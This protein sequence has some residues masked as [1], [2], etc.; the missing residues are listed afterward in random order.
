MTD[1]E[2]IKRAKKAV[3][4]RPGTYKNYDVRMVWYC[5]LAGN[6]KAMFMSPANSNYY[7]VTYIAKEDDLIV[8]QYVG[9][10]M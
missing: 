2:F 8:D 5:Y 10:D 7:E 6:Y 1:E 3:S 4:G 9:L